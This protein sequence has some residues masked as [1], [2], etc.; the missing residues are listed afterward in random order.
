MTTM[1]IITQ[2]QAN[3]V[4]EDEA[5][6]SEVKELPESPVLV[7]IDVNG[8]TNT[9]QRPVGKYYDMFNGP[10]AIKKKKEQATVSITPGGTAVKA[11]QRKRRRNG[12]KTEPPPKKQSKAMAEIDRKAIAALKNQEL[13]ELKARFDKNQET[14][15]S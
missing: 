12:M 2:T 4:S 15:K 8:A 6:T 14:W 10:S 1:N 9:F 7:A 11:H 13:F 3:D 5:E